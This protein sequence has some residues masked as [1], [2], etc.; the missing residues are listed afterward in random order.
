MLTYKKVK[1]AIP[2][3]TDYEHKVFKF[4]FYN[5]PPVKK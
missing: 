5:N 4:H 3:I 1:N 2:I